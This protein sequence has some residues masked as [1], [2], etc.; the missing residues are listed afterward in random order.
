MIG[1]PRQSRWPLMTAADLRRAA[2]DRTF[3]HGDT[4]DS[5]MDF[6]Q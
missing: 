1:E 2:R 5:M 4:T 6:S 3:L